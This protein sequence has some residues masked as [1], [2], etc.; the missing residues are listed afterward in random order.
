MS[1]EPQ[2]TNLTRLL[3]SPDKGQSRTYGI[4]GI[5]ANLFRK[6]LYARGIGHSRWTQ[7]LDRY[8]RKLNQQG[9]S[10]S[11]INSIR[12]NLTKALVKD[13]LTFKSLCRG[14][15]F[16]EAEEFTITIS[17]KFKDGAT[18]TVQS[19]VRLD[20]AQPVDDVDEEEE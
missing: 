11:T 12:G 7:L 4:G 18:T 14:I 17:A 10:S 19:V 6:L 15:D 13:E 20:N 16:L 8:I 5:L 9:N 2:G 3:M 1:R